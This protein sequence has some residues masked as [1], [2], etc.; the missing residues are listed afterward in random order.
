MKKES[1]LKEE[2]DSLRSTDLACSFGSIREEA[3]SIVEKFNAKIAVVHFSI[4]I[5]RESE[6][7]KESVKRIKM[8]KTSPPVRWTY[9]K[10]QE[11]LLD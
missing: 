5:N 3:S 7:K 1:K 11:K 4:D 6:A 10:E 9:E 2:L 8:M